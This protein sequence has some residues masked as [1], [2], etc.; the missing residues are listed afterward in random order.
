MDAPIGFANGLRELGLARGVSMKVVAVI[1]D[2][3]AGSGAMASSVAG[4][5]RDRGLRVE[6]S[7]SNWLQCPSAFSTT[8]RSTRRNSPPSIRRG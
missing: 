5:A 1:D 2:N 7:I 8:R 3:G 6:V 4:A